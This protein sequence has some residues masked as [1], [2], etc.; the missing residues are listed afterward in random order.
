M[1]AQDALAA[2]DIVISQLFPL[3]RRCAMLFTATRSVDS[4]CSHVHFSLAFLAKLFDKT[5]DTELPASYK[6]SLDRASVSLTGLVLHCSY[7]KHS[8][9]SDGIFR[10]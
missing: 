7:R 6:D 9:R 3:A 10:F 1:R 8:Y 2:V 5:F 4:L